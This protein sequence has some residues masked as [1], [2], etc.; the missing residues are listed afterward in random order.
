VGGIERAVLPDALEEL[1][2]PGANGLAVQESGQEEVPVVL[3]PRAE[4]VGIS[5][6]GIGRTEPSERILGE[7]ERAST[8]G[9]RPHVNRPARPEG[10]SRAG[11]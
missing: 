2:A 6:Q 4:R 10:S 1:H 11:S 3:Q 8:R 7:V 5:D 9:R